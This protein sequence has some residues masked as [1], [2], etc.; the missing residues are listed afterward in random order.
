MGHKYQHQGLQRRNPW[1]KVC[2]LIDS[3]RYFY[4]LLLFQTVQESRVECWKVRSL[5]L[6]VPDLLF[7]VLEEKIVFQLSMLVDLDNP[8]TLMT[9][10][11]RPRMAPRN[12]RLRLMDLRLMTFL[13]EYCWVR[14]KVARCE[15][16]D[17]STAILSYHDISYQKKQ[18]LMRLM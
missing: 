13:I 5:Y 3:T 4:Q 7:V 15:M 1:L 16:Q 9:S 17:I 11:R 10:Q 2:G 12:L 18:V 14:V 8:R 6:C